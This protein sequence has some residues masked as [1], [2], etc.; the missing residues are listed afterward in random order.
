MCRNHPLHQ[1]LRL[2]RDHHA[3]HVCYLS[4]GH[5]K[6]LECRQHRLHHPLHE[7]LCLHCHPIEL[8]T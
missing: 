7:S 8:G 2:P 6:T 1:F 4:K 3:C 5:P